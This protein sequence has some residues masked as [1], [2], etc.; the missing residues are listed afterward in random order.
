MQKNAQNIWKLNNTHLNNPQVKG[1]FL[2]EVL[3]ILNLIKMKNQ[4]IKI[5]WV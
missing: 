2:R 4:H 5:S 1:E 3:N